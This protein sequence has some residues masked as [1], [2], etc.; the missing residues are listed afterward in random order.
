MSVLLVT[1]CGNIVIDLFIDECPI[2]CNNFLKLCKIKYYN[3]NLF[4]NIQHDYIAQT[5]DPTG[6]GHGGNSIYGHIKNERS[7]FQNEVFKNKKHNKIGLVSMAN[8]GKEDSNFSQFFITLRGENMDHL[9]MKHT[10]FGEVAEGEEILQILNEL[11]CDEDGRPYQDV[12]IRHTYILED[13]FPE[14]IINNPPESPSSSSSSSLIPVLEKVK[15]RIPY[16]NGIDAPNEQKIKELEDSLRRKEAASRAVILE[17]TGDL[18]SADAKPPAEVLFVCK[19][20]SV[21]TSE[22]LELIFSRF[23]SITSC[24]VIRD[25]KTADSLCYAFIGFETEASCI[26]AYDKMNNVLIDDRRIKVDFSQSVAH[27][28]NRYKMQPR[29]EQQKQQPQKNKSQQYHNHKSDG[30]DQK[31]YR[32][33]DS[34]SSSDMSDDDD[35]KDYKKSKKSKK[36]KKHKKEKK[37]KKEKRKRRNG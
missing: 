32:D 14:P 12:R 33:H 7:S 17:M 1:S 9:D 22:D 4:F 21:T 29:K 26:E 34:Y 19:L 20:N 16:E 3:N 8:D 30:H 23:G 24:E 27:L 28:W 25:V 6:T 35:S 2:A 15:P 31:R 5:G 36:E 13:P 18:P 11:Y 10:I 37:E